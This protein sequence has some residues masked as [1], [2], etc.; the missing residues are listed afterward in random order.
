[1]TVSTS[2]LA[3]ENESPTDEGDAEE[4]SALIGRLFNE[5]NESL[6]RFLAARLRSRQEAKEV[7]QEAY[8]KLLSLDSPAAVSFLRAFLFKTAANLAYDR[9]RSRGRHTHA[10]ELGFFDE[11]REV[12][13]PEREIAAQQ[14]LAVLQQ[15]AGELPPKC[16]RA[17]LL[18]RIHGLDFADIAQRMD[19][20][21]RMVRVYVMRALLYCQ[22]G[23][24]RANQL[25]R[26][27]P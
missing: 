26:S 25:T 24:E 7:A 19:L 18:H 14:D 12:P 17:F 11:L 16:R 15:L 3:R 13:T 1:M 2:P 23:L 22:A 6:V 9:I 20:S 10:A 8:V 21:E 27:Q 5:H 4:H